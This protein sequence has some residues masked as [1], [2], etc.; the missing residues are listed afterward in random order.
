M[1]H[2][3][4]YTFADRKKT[5]ATIEKDLTLHVTPINGDSR[6]VA[7]DSNDKIVSEGKTPKEALNSAKLVK[8]GEKL[9]LMFIPI[10]VRV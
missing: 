9:F 4:I 10:K 1:F 5:M 6:W 8:Q 7:L 3:F 2:I